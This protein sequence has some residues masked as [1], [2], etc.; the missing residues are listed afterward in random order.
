MAGP[1]SLKI[2][3]TEIRKSVA[4]PTAAINGV[5]GPAMASRR[6]EL[7]LYGGDTFPSLACNRQATEFL[8][9]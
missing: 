5:D 2:E 9:C 8:P 4:K 1:A 3:Q 6:G 7:T